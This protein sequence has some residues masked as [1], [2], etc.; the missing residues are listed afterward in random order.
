M[1][2]PKKVIDLM[3]YAPNEGVFDVALDANESFIELDE[4]IVNELSEKIKGLNFNRYPDPT[5]KK[6]RQAFANFYSL[7][8]ECCVASNGS[9]EIISVIVNC[10][11]QKGDKI[12]TLAPDFSMYRF[13]S[14][15]AETETLEINKQGD[16][17]KDIK[18]II[19]AVNE[20][21][22]DMIIFSNPCNPTGKIFTKEEIRLLLK[23]CQ[24]LFVLDEAYMDF[25]DQS[26]LPEFEKYNNLII[27]KTCSK[28][29]GLACLRI[30]F[31]VTV[32]E[33]ADKLLAVKSPYNVNSVSQLMGENVLQKKE[34]ISSCIDKIIENKNMLCKGIEEL[35]QK[36]QNIF[37]SEKTYTNFAVIKTK[38]ATPIFEFLKTKKISV[39]CFKD[40]LRV[41]A[42]SEKENKVFLQAFEEYLKGRERI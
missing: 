8:W 5:A 24:C 26:M 10:L 15:L 25:S 23:S 3:P 17:D 42:G 28:A 19:K 11:T 13:Y 22:P 18:E 40:F 33:L 16:S 31:A 29:F 34:Y 14:H 39:R 1:Q 9:D 41:T 20:Q 27:L 12:L 21:K 32:K 7:P 36:Y 2:L 37:K 38:E 4:K 30:G 35:E 6:L